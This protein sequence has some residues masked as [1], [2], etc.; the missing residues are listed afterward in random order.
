MPQNVYIYLV[1]LYNF[2]PL[3][4]DQ[5]AHCVLYRVELAAI[6]RCVKAVC[7][8]LNKDGEETSSVKSDSASSQKPLQSLKLQT[9]SLLVLCQRK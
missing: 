3:H 2:C 5:L 9:N 4:I 6:T 1:R 8:C 7:V